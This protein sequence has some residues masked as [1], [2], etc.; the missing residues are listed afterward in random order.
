[1]CLIHSLG[2]KQADCRALLTVSSWEP[3]LVWGGAEL[4]RVDGRSGI[5]E[6]P[7]RLRGSMLWIVVVLRLGAPA[8]RV[9]A[10]EDAP[11]LAQR[12]LATSPL[13]PCPWQ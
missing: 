9:S 3:N 5:L 6:A 11:V 1:M 4:R 2:P 12:A 13:A 10:L 7:G 8:Q